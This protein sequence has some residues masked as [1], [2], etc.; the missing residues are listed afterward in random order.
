MGVIMYPTELLEKPIPQLD[1]EMYPA[2]IAFNM[3]EI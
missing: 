1:E 2:I 3:L